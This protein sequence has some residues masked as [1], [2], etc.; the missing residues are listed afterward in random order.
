MGK[1]HGPSAIFPHKLGDNKRLW[2]FGKSFQGYRD[3]SR[4]LILAYARL[5]CFLDSD[6]VFSGT[7]V[8]WGAVICLSRTGHFVGAGLE[9]PADL[10]LPV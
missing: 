8:S 10:T 6:L 1:S 4:G 9:T 5:G 3:R 2:H 7:R